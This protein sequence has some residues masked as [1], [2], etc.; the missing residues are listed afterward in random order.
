M[1]LN[2]NILLF[3]L[4]LSSSHLN[5]NAKINNKEEAEKFLDNYCIVI[6]SSIKEAYELQIKSV[7]NQDWKTF[8]EKG[9][10]IGGLAD[11]YSKLCK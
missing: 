1:R 4:L 5:V 10:W 8:G 11:V 2:K 6:V 9:R 7:S 3:L